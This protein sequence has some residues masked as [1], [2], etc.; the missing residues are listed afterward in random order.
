MQAVHF[1]QSCRLHTPGVTGC[2]WPCS[3]ALGVLRP[4]FPRQRPAD[5]KSHFT[6]DHGHHHRPQR[7][8]VAMSLGSS[9]LSNILLLAACAT[10][11]TWPNP[12]LDE[13]ESLLYDQHGFNE[14]GILAGALTPCNAF[15]FGSTVN[16]SNA[17]DW[18]RTVRFASHLR[19]HA[20]W[21]MWMGWTGP[22]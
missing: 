11:Y 18:I 20:L 19:L 13:L 12:Q 9:R 8:I 6:F 1:V 2:S 5:Y 21:L 4:T 15:G 16:R 14:R 22:A 17:A 3:T 10:A 7:P